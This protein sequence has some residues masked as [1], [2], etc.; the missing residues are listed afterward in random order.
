MPSC[1]NGVCCSF[2]TMQS[3]IS[4]VMFFP[5]RPP[6]A[7]LVGSL[8]RPIDVCSSRQRCRHTHNLSQLCKYFRLREFFISN[9]VANSSRPNKTQLVLIVS[10]SIRL[11]LASMPITL[12]HNFLLF[13]IVYFI[14][15]FPLSANQRAF[16]RIR[17]SIHSIR[18]EHPTH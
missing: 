10:K 2:S 1:L 13:Q 18:S 17:A 7:R 14:V 6:L 12:F 15:W 5:L 8:A 9:I 4:S 16:Y 11:S 3:K